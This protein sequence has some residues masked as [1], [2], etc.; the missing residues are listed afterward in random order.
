MSADGLVFGISPTPPILAFPAISPLVAV[1]RCGRSERN[2]LDRSKLSDDC[3]S[4]DHQLFKA[5]P[6]PLANSIGRE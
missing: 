6:A 2:L 4:L 5:P 1:L 3:L